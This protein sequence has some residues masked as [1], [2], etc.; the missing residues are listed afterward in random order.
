ED[1]VQ[2]P[3][4]NVILQAIGA[5]EV[6]KVAVSMFQLHQGDILLMCTDGLSNLVNTGEMLFFA[7]S[8]TPPEACDQL[9]ELAKQRGGPDNIT[10][11][12]AKFDGDGLGAKPPSN[13]L[14]G[15]LQNLSTY[16]PEQEVQKSHKR[17]QLL[18]NS[19]ALSPEALS[20]LLAGKAPKFQPAT[21]LAGAPNCPTVKRE[22]ELLIEWVEY[23]HKILE[24]KT[25]QV[26]E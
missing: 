2:H 12:L 9:I 18:G 16:D 5:R 24:L 4:K 21:S 26:I 15:L 11:I 7:G 10:C 14:T 1:A 6:I 20:G 8:K 25:K 17:T 19:G 23:S 13:R 22:C 3:R